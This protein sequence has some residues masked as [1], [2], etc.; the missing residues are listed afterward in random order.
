MSKDTVTGGT[1]GTTELTESDGAS[2]EHR[3]KM[4]MDYTKFHIG[5]YAVVI[6]TLIALSQIGG[7][8]KVV[9]EHFR[10][11]IVISL[12]LILLAGLCGGVIAGNLPE[13]KK[14][15]DFWGTN[16]G[17]WFFPYLPAK[18]W[19]RLEHIF[20][21]VSVVNAVAAVLFGQAYWFASASAP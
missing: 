21:W 10:F 13:Q 20:F 2:D 15:D 14:F 4:L 1:G 8:G 3:L 11:P 6:T 12:V 17:P 18:I 16:T 5:L 19:A 7:D 9:E